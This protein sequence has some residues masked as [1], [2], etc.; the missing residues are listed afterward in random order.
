MESGHMRALAIVPTYNE[1]DNLPLLAPAIL[2]QG[3]SIE[4]LII[5]DAS[6]D[7]TGRVADALA[8]A[9]HRIH[10]LHRAG[11]QG[12][13]TAYLAGFRYAIDHAFDAVCQ[14]DADFS[15]NPADLPRLL[16][17]LEDADV[18]IGSR[19]TRGGGAVNWPLSRQLLSR[20]GSLYARAML[21]VPIHDLTAGFTCYRRTALERL[22]LTTTR[23]TGYG[24]QLEMKY[25]CARAGLRMVEVPIIFADRVRGQSKMSQR[26]LVEALL[27]V[28]RLRYRTRFA[29]VGGRGA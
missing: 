2:A 19:W 22:D 23:A 11:K 5:D 10:V 24:F 20:G 28:P 16:A 9:D 27:L 17:A 14:V 13:A 29:A 1:R 15:H 21:G 8:E 6:P 7:G 12:V 26:I 3:A 4:L 18:A 25:A